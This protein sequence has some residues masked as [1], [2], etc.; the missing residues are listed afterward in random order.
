M[1]CQRETPS[2]LYGGI[3]YE[4]INNILSLLPDADLLGRN[5]CWCEFVASSEK[6]DG[7][8]KTPINNFPAIRFPFPPLLARSWLLHSALALQHLGRQ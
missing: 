8:Y 4:L 3:F 7:S 5:R 2:F 1:R 6:A